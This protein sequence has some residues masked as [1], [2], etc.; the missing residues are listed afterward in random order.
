MEATMNPNSVEVVAR[1]RYRQKVCSLISL[2]RGNWFV[3]FI[4]GIQRS[5]KL[6]A[7][8]WRFGLTQLGLTQPN[9]AAPAATTPRRNACTAL[10]A[11][12]PTGSAFPKTVL[13]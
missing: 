11:A 13:I 3:K 5:V 6:V 7:F 9:Y 2:S 1:T 10:S 12:A 8:A 4:H